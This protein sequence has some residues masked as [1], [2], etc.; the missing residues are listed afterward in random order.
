MKRE[1]S[2]AS[3]HLR[4]LALASRPSDLVEM[5]DLARA[6]SARGH[7]L[8]LLY[9]Y[10]SGDPSS[11]AEIRRLKTIGSEARIDTA[12]VE[13]TNLPPAAFRT[14]RELALSEAAAA[15]AAAANVAMAKTRGLLG[16]LLRFKIAINVKVRRPTMPSLYPVLHSTVAWLRRNNLNFYP[17]NTWISRSIYTGLFKL[18]QL[19]P[20]EVW[21]TFRQ[22]LRLRKELN[23]QAIAGEGPTLDLA[24]QSAAMVGRYK[25]FLAFFGGAI[26][27]RSFD[28]LLLP[29]DIVGDIWP[30]AIAAAHGADVPALVLPYTL[31]NREEAIQSL[32][33]EA[34]FQTQNNE[35]AARLYPRWRYQQEDIDLVRLPAGH[36]FA[37]ETLGIAPPDPWMM[38][39]GYADK[40]LVDSDASLQYFSAGGIPT[41]Q[42]AIVGSTS[43]DRMFALRQQRAVE[44]NKVRKALGLTGTKPMLLLSGCPNQ[45]SASVPFCE[46]QNMEE[47]AEFIGK[48]LVTLAPHYH[49]VV[50]PHPNFMA[51][52]EMLQPYGIRSTSLPTASLVPLSDVFIAFASATLR[53]AIACGIPSINYDVFHYCYS[54]FDT[55]KGVRTVT[56]TTQFRNAMQYLVPGSAELAALAS[57]AERD[58]ALWSLMDGGSVFRIEQEIHKARRHLKLVKEQSQNV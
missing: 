6:L 3:E 34:A 49:L 14:H 45:L 32:K 57:N 37:H 4:L 58:S 7:A 11:A 8:T 55:A 53:W 54:D 56:A 25:R 9:F 29:E 40:I 16:T 42:M 47:V 22:M 31:A 39:S 38:N 23:N 5:S 50:R 19:T 51:F 18:D 48:N 27:S 28:A 2:Q 44:L 41:E 26:R 36:I 10:S 1:R 30:V 35:L 20:R 46:F 17:K 13:V 24:F 33:G 15:A 43:Q 52:G 21:D 12:S